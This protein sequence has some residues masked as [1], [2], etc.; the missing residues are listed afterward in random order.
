MECFTFDTFGA[1]AIKLA[2]QSPDSFI[3]TALQVAFY[4]VQGG[5]PAHYESAGLRRF[6]NTRT[7]CIRSTSSDSVSF[8]KLMAN[9]SGSKMQRKEAMIRAI[10]THKRIASEVTLLLKLLIIHF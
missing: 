5:P 6:R 1:S 4:K 8:A 7:E 9:D 2:K 10:D 3:Q